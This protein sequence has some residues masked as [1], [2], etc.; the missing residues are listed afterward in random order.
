MNLDEKV[1]VSVGCLN[2]L[3]SEVEG[4]RRQN[5]MMGIENRTINRF[6]N[7][8]ESIQP[9]S[10]NVGCSVDSLWQAKRE[11]DQAIQENRIAKEQKTQ[12]K[13]L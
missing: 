8:A 1:S 11:I 13:D 10:N 7:F 3:T 5:E 2:Y 4:L 12:S 9:K 6:L